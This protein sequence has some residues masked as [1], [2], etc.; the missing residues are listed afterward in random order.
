[1]ASERRRVRWWLKWVGA[2]WC[3]VL[4]AAFVASIWMACG[5]STGPQGTMCI[6]SGGAITLMAPGWISAGWHWVEPPA[7]GVAWRPVFGF[8]GGYGGL[9]TFRL[10]PLWCLLAPIAVGTAVLWWSDRRWPSGRCRRCGY[11]LTGNVSGVCP[12]CGT[13]TQV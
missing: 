1:M 4:I 5:Y 9:G 13:E 8:P 10:I 11:D 6:I 3:V 2:G 12:E 7:E